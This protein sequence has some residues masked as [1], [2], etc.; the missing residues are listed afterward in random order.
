MKN[1]GG[2]ERSTLYSYAA[3]IRGERENGREQLL[4]T[5]FS[6]RGKRSYTLRKGECSVNNLLPLAFRKEE[7]FEVDFH[8]SRL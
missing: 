8:S 4:I 6:L 2:R 5:L 7:K 1:L 3:A